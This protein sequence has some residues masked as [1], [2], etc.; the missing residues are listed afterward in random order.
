MPTE[1]PL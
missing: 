1:L